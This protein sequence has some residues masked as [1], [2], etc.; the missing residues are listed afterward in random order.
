MSTM[1]KVLDEFNEL[2]EKTNEHYAV[3]LIKVMMNL[4]VNSKGNWF[5]KYWKKWQCKDSH[6][7]LN[8]LENI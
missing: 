8:Q 4:I 1:K 3:I 2:I 7:K 6:M 5:L